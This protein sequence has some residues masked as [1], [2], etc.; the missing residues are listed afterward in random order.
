MYQ[1]GTGLRKSRALKFDI[2]QEQHTS[3]P[4]HYFTVSIN[5]SST[6]KLTRVK[7]F[8]T[9]RRS[10]IFLAIYQTMNIKIKYT[11][12]QILRTQSQN[13]KHLSTINIINNVMSEFQTE[14]IE[15]YIK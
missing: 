8:M 9:L 5:F 7:F 13:K 2:Q 11:C 12:Y 4:F 15:L 10:R 6:T 3:Q 14:K 1:V